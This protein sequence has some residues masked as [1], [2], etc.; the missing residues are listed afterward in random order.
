MSPACPLPRPNLSSAQTWY[1]SALVSHAC[2]LTRQIII[3][4]QTWYRSALVS[5]GLPT[6]PSNYTMISPQTWYRSALVSHACPLTRQTIIS[7]QTWYRSALKVYTHGHD[8]AVARASCIITGCTSSLCDASAS[9][10]GHVDTGT[11]SSRGG[12]WPR[13]VF[14]IHPAGF[15]RWVKTAHQ[16]ANRLADLTSARPYP[17]QDRC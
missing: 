10:S 2:P 15:D 7:P 12:P 4:P 14:K 9:P 5:H 13:S 1:R 11:Q 6:D 8:A 17:W 3:S 16:Q